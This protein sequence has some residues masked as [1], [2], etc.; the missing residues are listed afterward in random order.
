MARFGGNESLNPNECSELDSSSGSDDE[1]GRR[2]GR[3]AMDDGKKKKRGRRSRFD[4][5]EDYMDDENN[6]EYGGWTRSELFRI[7][8]AALLFGYVYIFS[9]S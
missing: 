9:L 3:S 7:E 6:V 2:R 8:K 1:D 5:D 4:E